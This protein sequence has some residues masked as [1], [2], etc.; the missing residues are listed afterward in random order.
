MD[1]VSTLLLSVGFFLMVMAT[2]FVM[3]K[4]S[5]DAGR[6]SETRRQTLYKEFK[7]FS[8]AGLSLFLLGFFG[9]FIPADIKVAKTIADTGSIILGLGIPQ[10]IQFSYSKDDSK[11]GKYK[12]DLNTWKWWLFAIGFVFAVSSPIISWVLNK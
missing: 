9:A 6:P 8:I 5:L 7:L 4:H 10:Y 12:K 1:I 3:I 2:R 11:Y